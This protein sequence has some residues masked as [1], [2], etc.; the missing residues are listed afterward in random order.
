MSTNHRERVMHR[1]QQQHLAS[2]PDDLD[3]KFTAAAVANPRD[4]GDWKKRRAALIQARGVLRQ[5]TGCVQLLDLADGEYYLH[6]R[7][8]LR[9]EEGV[10]ICSK[11]VFHDGPII[12]FV[13][14]EED[15]ARLGNTS[16]SRSIKWFDD[17]ELN[18]P[19]LL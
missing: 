16:G 15:D 12:P 10:A 9:D 1:V 14:P 13:C 17:E 8:P 18:Q 3:A 5:M 11:C 4:T 19:Q 2:G 6:A 7:S